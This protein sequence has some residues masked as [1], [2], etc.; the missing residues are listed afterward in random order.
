MKKIL[1]AVALISMCFSCKKELDDWKED[2]AYM[3]LPRECKFLESKHT[4]LKLNDDVPSYIEPYYSLEIL[5]KGQDVESEDYVIYIMTSNK[6]FLDSNENFD[7]IN[8]PYYVIPEAGNYFTDTPD[9]E[10]EQQIEAFLGR[11]K[12]LKSASMDYVFLVEVEYRTSQLKRINVSST[13]PLFNQ[14]AGNSLNDYMAIRSVS[15]GCIFDHDIPH[16]KMHLGQKWA[17]LPT[18]I[19]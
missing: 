9:Y 10:M 5:P 12:N 3:F 17:D 1:I 6:K 14:N 15:N 19:M 2:T 4:Y 7:F 11:N 13:I 18:S 8:M 16:Y